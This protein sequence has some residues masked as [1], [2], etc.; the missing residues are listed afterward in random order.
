MA[1]FIIVAR[2]LVLALCLITLPHIY[3]QFTAD[4]DST[5]DRD[6]RGRLVNGGNSS[7][8]GLVVEVTS[9]GADGVRARTDVS[10]DG[11]FLFRRLPQGDYI[12]RVL[13]PYGDEITSTSTSTGIAL[14]LEIPLTQTKLSRPVSGTVSVQELSH[15]PSKHTRKLL[16]NGER[17]LHEEHFDEAASRFREATK[18]DPDCLQAHADLGQ[19]L[20]G[21]ADW[22]G[23]AE[24]F[25]A[26]IA[27]NPRASILHSN[28]G[29]ALAAT[30][31]FDDAEHEVV[32]ALKLD[33]RNAR[34]HFVMAALLLRK[35]GQLPQAVSHLVAAQDKLPSAKTAVEKICAANHVPGCP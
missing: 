9:L 31:R 5:S 24:E 4:M 3:G 23:A 8:T 17:L 13:T 21:I 32:A 10:S 16:E 34:A 6:L 33:S 27:L 28:L 20:A 1:V 11:S 15:P 25:R 7:Y 14:P 29:A 35:E 18:N 30:Q 22:N 12:V 2:Y 19:A 26:A